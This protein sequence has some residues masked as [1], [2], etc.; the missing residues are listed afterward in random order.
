MGQGDCLMVKSHQ[1]HGRPHK[2]SIGEIDGWCDQYKKQL[3]IHINIDESE[4]SKR[5]LE[6]AIHES[7]HACNWKASEDNVTQTAYDIARFLWRLGYRKS[8]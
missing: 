6:T 8:K 7:L 2:I 5:F 4:D 3:Y 1:F